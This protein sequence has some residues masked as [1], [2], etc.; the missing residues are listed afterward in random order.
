M[1]AV[2][3]GLTMLPERRNGRY[4]PVAPATWRTDSWF[5]IYTSLSISFAYFIAAQ[6]YHL[7]SHLSSTRNYH[8]SFTFQYNAKLSL[9]FAFLYNT[10][11]SLSFAQRYY[12]VS[13][14]DIA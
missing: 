2:H 5:A 3:F 13:R 4:F 12:L 14:F 6:G 8:F 1:N 9:S 11:L 7:A 10:K